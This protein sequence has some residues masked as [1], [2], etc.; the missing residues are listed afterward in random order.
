MTFSGAT[1]S[2]LPQDPERFAVG[3]G[4][5]ADRLHLTLVWLGS[6]D[7][8]AVPFDDAVA[9]VAPLAGSGVIE[10]D[11]W[12]SGWF[13]PADDGGAAVLLVGSEQLTLLRDGI[14]TEV[15][16]A[17]QHPNWVPHIT[18]GY[19]ID[20]DADAV[21]ERVGPVVF[22]RVQVAYGDQTETVDLAADGLSASAA[23][24]VEGVLAVEGT[25]TGDGRMFE[26]GSLR[27][28]VP[29]PLRWASTD[30]GAHNGAVSVGRILEVWRD[31]DVI[32]WS[33]DLNLDTDA[34]AEL[35]RLLAGDDQGAWVS[36]ISVDVDDTDVEIRVAADL[37]DE[38]E[39]EYADEDGAEREVDDDGRVVVWEY[40]ADDELLVVV[41]GRVRAATVVDI[42]A[43]VEATI[44]LADRPAPA[45]PALTAAA[46][47][48]RPPA[49]W[50]AD[51]G[52]QGPTAL[53]VT[54]EGR[55]YG[56]LATW[57]TCHTGFADSCVTPPRSQASYRH[58]RVGAVV[59]DDG[60]EVA[61]GRITLD[62]LHAP[63]RAGAGAAL[64]HYEDTGVAVA[65]VA[66]GEDE[67]G[68]WVAGALR[69]GVTE[70]QVRVLRASPLSGDWRRIG[71][72][73]ELVA[74]LAVNSPGFPVPRAL[75][76]SGKVQT[77]QTP[78]LPPSEPDRDD[79][80]ILVS[81]IRQ[82]RQRRRD[83]AEAARTRMLVASSAV[84]MRRD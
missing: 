70:E 44:R 55:V 25:P 23:V 75:V 61:T 37:L 45:G 35:H 82:E 84:R 69:P 18:L 7:D 56:H 34:G 31:G 2:L 53:Q 54:D 79:Q 14:V 52:L 1:V 16:D 78:G 26:R 4:D 68:V 39:A 48:A 24:A 66:A 13:N 6:A 51:P 67:W 64:S 76:A 10:A 11:V 17:S 36:G 62:T 29:M 83:A 73:L 3:D 65:D 9:A 49:R 74:A 60:S 42:P 5:P 43:F 63:R 72:N 80:E 20:L 30:E 41:D 15:G 46:A 71:G 21:K 81:M 40:A 22:D 59:V 33:G 47:P 38:W 8:P 58:F 50:F 27:W 28:D 77:L 57:D 12:G 32:R 19:G